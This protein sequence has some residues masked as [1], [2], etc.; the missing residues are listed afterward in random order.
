[1]AA[2]FQRHRKLSEDDVRAIVA[3]AR[4]G[5]TQAELARRYGVSLGAINYRLSK[6]LERPMDRQHCATCTCMMRGI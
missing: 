1:M 4:S 2:G 5:V 6:V 3:A